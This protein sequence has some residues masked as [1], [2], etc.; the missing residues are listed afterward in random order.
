MS[1]LNISKNCKD[2]SCS[3]KIEQTKSS[4]KNGGSYLKH[5]YFT[6]HAQ[7]KNKLKIRIYQKHMHLYV[8]YP[9]K[10]P[11]LNARLCVR[12]ISCYL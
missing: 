8:L 11:E 6:A 12:N 4:V 9:V 1:I 7:I 10:K 2:Q 5:F 3:K